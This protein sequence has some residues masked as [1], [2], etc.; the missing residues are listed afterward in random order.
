MLI[1]KTKKLIKPSVPSVPDVPSEMWLDERL[2]VCYADYLSSWQ[3]LDRLNSIAERIVRSGSFG[4]DR[5]WY[6][7][8]A[9]DFR[10]WYNIQPFDLFSEARKLYETI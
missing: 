6:F 9:D 8:D 4:P 1:K 2:I 7:V 10:K 5:V 3:S